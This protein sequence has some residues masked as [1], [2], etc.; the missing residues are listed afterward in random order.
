MPDDQNSISNTQSLKYQE[1]LPYTA[2]MIQNSRQLN[3]G[4][5]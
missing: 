4:K 1:I 2:A 5:N 3:N